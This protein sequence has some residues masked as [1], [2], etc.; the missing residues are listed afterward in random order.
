MFEDELKK[1]KQDFPPEILIPYK[2]Q[3]FKNYYIKRLKD[4]AEENIRRS[5]EKVNSKNRRE[6]MDKISQK[7]EISE[8][9]EFIERKIDS[10]IAYFRI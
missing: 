9:K 2:I 7:Y 5:Y 8:Q 4:M 3:K 10:D 6:L 1:I